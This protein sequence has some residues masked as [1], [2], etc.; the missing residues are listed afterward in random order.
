MGSGIVCGMVF[1]AVSRL[2]GLNRKW[3]AWEMS[4]HGYY[5]MHFFLLCPEDHMERATA[6]ECEE[7]QE[8]RMER[9]TANESEEIHD[10]HMEKAEA[11]PHNTIHSWTKILL[12]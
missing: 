6:N 3:R 4:I 1:V 5:S 2:T 9:A 11:I 7:I 10:E 8:D 12:T